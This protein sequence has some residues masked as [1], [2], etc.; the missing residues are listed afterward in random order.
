MVYMISFGSLP[1]GE[2]KE[3]SIK[4]SLSDNLTSNFYICAISKTFDIYSEFG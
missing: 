1:I 3:I 2:P 4:K